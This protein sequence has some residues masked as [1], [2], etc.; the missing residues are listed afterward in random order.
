MP[1]YYPLGQF[2]IQHYLPVY[3]KRDLTPE[4]KK[5]IERGLRKWLPKIF[6]SYGTPVSELMSSP[7]KL[8]LLAGLGT[9]GLT[10]PLALGLALGYGGKEGVD[11]TIPAIAGVGGSALLSLLVGL[12]ARYSR[13]ARNEDLIDLMKRMPAGQMATYRDILADPIE[14]RRNFVAQNMANMATAGVG[15]GLIG[16]ALAR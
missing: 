5:E 3:E 12:L 8:G 4:E 15:G 6:V 13:K 14:Q 7:N 11:A 10:S 9:F 16:S 1:R 2:G